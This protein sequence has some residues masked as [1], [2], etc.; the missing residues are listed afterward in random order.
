MTTITPYHRPTY[1]QY[2]SYGHNRQTAAILSH[3]WI[4]MC[5]MV[6]L[7]LILGVAL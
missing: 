6:L 7:G 5:T 3:P 1:S 2:R 4:F